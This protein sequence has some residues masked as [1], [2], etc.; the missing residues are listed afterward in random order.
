MDVCDSAANA[1]PRRSTTRGPRCRWDSQ[2]L[3]NPGS[4]VKVCA[5]TP[6]RAR[7]VDKCAPCMPGNCER[8]L[9]RTVALQISRRPM[10]NS[11]GQASSLVYMWWPSAVFLC[12][13]PRAPSR[14]PP[15]KPPP[16]R[17]EAIARNFVKGSNGCCLDAVAAAAPH[18]SKTRR[19]RIAN[20]KAQLSQ[21]MLEN[22]RWAAKGSRV[23]GDAVQPPD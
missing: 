18:R 10:R 14:R 9:R 21:R 1:K 6:R 5:A 12:V 11:I 23:S 22:A 3:C 20:D 16:Q 19:P 17:S 13:W 8:M 4:S 2:P 7:P 15:T